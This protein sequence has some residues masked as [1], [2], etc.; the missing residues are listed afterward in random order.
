MY[1]WNRLRLK[2]LSYAWI[3]INVYFCQH[4]FSLGFLDNFFKYWSQLL[5]RPAPWSV[6][7]ALV[8]SSEPTAMVRKVYSQFS[9]PYAPHAERW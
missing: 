1:R 7:P 4:Y 8:R 6:S 5:T 2:S 9:T 3:F